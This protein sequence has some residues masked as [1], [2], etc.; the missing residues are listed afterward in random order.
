M[1]IKLIYFL[2]FRN[3][4]YIFKITFDKMI[5]ELYGKKDLLKLLFF[6]CVYV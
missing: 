4:I 1:L 3:S 2:G 5:A 6:T